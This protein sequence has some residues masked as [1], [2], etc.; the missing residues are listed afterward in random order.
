VALLQLEPEAQR[1]LLKV[2]AEARDRD[3]MF[4]YLRA[5]AA[6]G[7]LGEVSLL[8]HQVQLYNPQKPIRFSL[9]ASFAGLH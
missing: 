1:R 3:A 6:S 4:A 5:L 2:T 9:Q 7:E 8:R